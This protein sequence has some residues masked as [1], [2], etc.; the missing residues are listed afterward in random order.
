[1]IQATTTTTTTTITSTMTSSRKRS[2]QQP[3]SSIMIVLLLLS[4]IAI[5]VTSSGSFVANA[6]SMTASSTPQGLRYLGAVEELQKQA[7]FEFEFEEDHEQEIEEQDN[8]DDD[9]WTSEQI[10]QMENLY[11]EYREVIVA[12]FGEDWEEEIELEKMEVIYERYLEFE[13]GRRLRGQ[14][15]ELR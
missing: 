14:T 5:I 3:S 9:E 13:G 4:L 11:E 10:E 15:F 1:M 8:E 12:K 7:L 6:L 2:R